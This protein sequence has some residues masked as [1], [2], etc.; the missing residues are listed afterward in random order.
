MN[1]NTLT[2]RRRPYRRSLRDEQAAATRG[3]ILEALAE[4]VVDAGMEDFSIAR[5]AERAGVAARTVYH[6]FPDREALMDG[7]YHYVEARLGFADVARPKS[8]DGLPAFT[9]STFRAIEG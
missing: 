3:R 9:E 7:L 2:S 6:H 4:Q 1:S 8:L 5:V